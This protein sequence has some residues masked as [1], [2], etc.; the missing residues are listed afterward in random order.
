MHIKIKEK[1]QL[2]ATPLP[3][4]IFQFTLLVQLSSGT[5][6]YIASQVTHNDFTRLYFMVEYFSKVY[7]LDDLQQKYNTVDQKGSLD[8]CKSLVTIKH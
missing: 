8:L 3:P 1:E 6:K 4:A 5:M 7:N 2:T